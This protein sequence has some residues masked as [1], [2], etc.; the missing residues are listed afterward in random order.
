MTR[1]LRL[2]TARLL[3]AF[4]VASV[5]SFAA[6]SSFAADDGFRPIFDGKTLNGWSSAP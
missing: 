3:T 1:L 2:L 4:A 6:N 5:V